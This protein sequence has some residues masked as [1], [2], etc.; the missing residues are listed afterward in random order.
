MDVG[1]GVWLESLLGNH[2]VSSS[3]PPCGT[4]GVFYYRHACGFADRN[5]AE[6]HVHKCMAVCFSQLEN[7][8]QF[9]YILLT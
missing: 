8:C 7:L 2:V 6:V 1:M 9:V 5:Y 4:L 3:V